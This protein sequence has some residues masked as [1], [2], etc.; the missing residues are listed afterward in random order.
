[1]T[2]II[3]SYPKPGYALPSRNPR[4]LIDDSGRSFYDLKKKI[5]TREF[6]KRLDKACSEAIDDQNKAD[7]DIVTDGEERREQYIL[8]NLRHLK[9]INFKDWVEISVREGV[10]KRWAPKIDGKIE[11]NKSWL[12]DDFKFASS[13]TSKI[14]KMTIPGPV[15]A[16]DVVFD[17]YYKGNR[18]KMAFDYAKAVRK[19]IS[20]LIDAGC[21]LIQFDDPVLLRNPERA[22]E[23]GLKALKE[24]FKGLENK[25]TFCVHICRG[26]PNKPLEKKGVNYK[27]NANYYGQ[28][29]SFLANSRLDQVSIE[30]EQSNLDLSVLPAIGKKT[31]VLG[32]LDV[33]SEKI[34]SVG[35]LVKRGQEALKFIK[36]AQ[37]VLAPDC[38]LLMI[39][40]K[41]AFGKLKNLAA[42]AKI[43]NKGV[44][45]WQ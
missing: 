33:G 12:V 25:A 40:R 45:K 42:A 11:Y 28:I 14:V 31:I 8:Y 29:L 27:A 39:S 24:C 4:K 22:K 23:W 18:K 41:A 19:E 37:L 21:K 26:Y 1:M 6:N 38:G 30:G 36:P 16:T 34:E 3:G 20:A 10:Y 5:G 7:L 35:H 32:V 13:K 44:L 43:L 17:T 9:G 2:T 15:T